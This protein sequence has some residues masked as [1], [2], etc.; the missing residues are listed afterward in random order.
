MENLPE[1]MKADRD[2]KVYY[3]TEKQ[4][5][6]MIHW[7]DTGNNEIPKRHYI[8]NPLVKE[9]RRNEYNENAFNY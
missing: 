4:M 8:D 7:I 6:Y 2:N 9:R 5:F 1:G 3:D